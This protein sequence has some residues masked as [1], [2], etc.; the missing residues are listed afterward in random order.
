MAYDP[1]N[2]PL[3]FMLVGVPKPDSIHIDVIAPDGSRS[4][5][6]M[7]GT[8]SYAAGVNQIAFS[9]AAHLPPKGST[10][11]VAYETSCP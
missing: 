9:D 10:L 7:T 6:S 4:P 5:L 3:S 2:P 1:S 8:W 11:D